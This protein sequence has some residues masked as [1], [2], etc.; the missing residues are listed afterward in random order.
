MR[1]AQSAF[2][3]FGFTG[4]AAAS[5]LA[6]AL[7]RHG[8]LSLWIVAGL[9]ACGAVTFLVVAM[10]TK[11]VTG[12]ESLTYYH[13]QIAVLP[14]SALMLWALRTPLLPYLDID[15]LGIGVFLAFGR[16]GCL[17][18]GCCYGLPCPRGARYGR[19]YMGSVLPR[20][21]AEIPL[22]P[23]QAI[24]SAGVLAIVILG[25]LQVA[26][27]HPPGSALSTYLVGYAFLRFFLEFLRGGTDRRFAWG[28]S[29]AQWTSLAVLGGTIGLEAQGTLP[30]EMWHVAAFAAIV[31]AAIALQLNPRLRSMHRLFH[32]SRI[33]EF[34]Q[35]LEFASHTAAAKHPL[36]ASSAI[37]VSATKMGIRVSGGYLS[38]GATSVWHYTLS[39]AGGSMSERTARLLATLASRLIGSAD[40]FKILPG[41]SGVYHLLPAGTFR[42]P[43][44]PGEER[45]PA[46]KRFGPRSSRVPGFDCNEEAEP[47]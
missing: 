11:V 4:F 39:Q 42:T 14:M 26:V 7:A 44:G 29:E 25:T 3:L 12:V 1:N 33:E 6:L 47:K 8:N 43:S 19:S 41:R 28:F 15:V 5:A 23:V 18:A 21:L 13:H 36:P 22:F 30:F 45:D 37:H 46:R 35:A 24:E 17:K 34:A 27:G 10:A 38:D 16:I 40:P 32:P 9:A 20:H 31:L 2:R